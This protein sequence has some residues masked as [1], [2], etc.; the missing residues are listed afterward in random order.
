[1]HIAIAQYLVDIAREAVSDQK[2]RGDIIYIADD[3][4]PDLIQI[5]WFDHDIAWNIWH[6]PN[7]WHVR[8]CT[9]NYRTLDLSNHEETAKYI[10]DRTTNIQNYLIDGS[11]KNWQKL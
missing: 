3:D 1:M 10:K 11:G 5:K 2:W 9:N 8:V 4:K 6:A 7:V